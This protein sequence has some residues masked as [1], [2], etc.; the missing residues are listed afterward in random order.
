MYTSREITVAEHAAWFEN[1]RYDTAR[2]LLIFEI[3]HQ[4][5]GFVNFKQLPEAASAIWGFYLAPGMPKGT[6]KVLGRVAMSYAFETLHL[7]KV[8]SEVLAFN[9]R[10]IRFHIGLGFECQQIKYQS[11]FEGCEHHDVHCF[12]LSL[13]KWTKFYKEVADE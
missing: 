2:Q 13:E 6:G 3:N 10:S 12:F 8:F 11:Y 9:E 4:P 1:A 5:S 7:R